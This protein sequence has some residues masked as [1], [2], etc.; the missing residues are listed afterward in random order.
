MQTRHR[1]ILN[2]NEF[3]FFLFMASS[4]SKT[5][6]DER[7]SLVINKQ[8]GFSGFESLKTSG[9][10]IV[11]KTKTKYECATSIFSLIQNQY[12]PQIILGMKHIFLY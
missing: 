2:L 9:L 10:N 12:L 11:K 5:R 8:K 3:L 6:K 4:S 7:P 1:N